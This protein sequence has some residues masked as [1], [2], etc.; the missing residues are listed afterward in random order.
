MVMLVCTAVDAA[1]SLQ[2]GL[3][4]VL[5]R[6][7]DPEAGQQRYMA[8]CSACHGTAGEGQA[9]GLAPRIAGQRFAVIAGELLGFRLGRA[10]AR[11]ATIG[12]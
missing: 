12:A 1:P 3:N 5:R 4:E 6:K 9:Q 11:L 7:P 2:S 8:E 10:G